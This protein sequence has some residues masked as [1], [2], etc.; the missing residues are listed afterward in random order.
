MNQTSAIAASLIVAWLIFITVRGELPVYI[1]I[2]NG[3]GPKC[4]SSAG[5]SSSGAGLQ[6]V[7]GGSGSGVTVGIKP[8]AIGIGPVTIQP[9]PISVGL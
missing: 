8:P 5:S 1:G 3:N 4:D 7:P 6:I 9:P 2:L